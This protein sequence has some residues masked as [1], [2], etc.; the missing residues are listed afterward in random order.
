MFCTNCGKEL[1]PNDRFCANCGCEVKGSQTESRKYDNVVFNPPFRMEAEKKTAQILRNRE[2]FR[3]FK[4]ISDETNRRSARSKAKM[5]WNLEGFPESVTAQGRKSSFDWDSVIERRNSGRSMGFEKIDLSST[6]EH[7]KVDPEKD[8]PKAEE[9]AEDKISLGLPP[10]DSRVISL[11]ELEKELYD[12]EE[13]LRTDTARTAKYEPFRDGEI[14]DSDEL[15]AY[16]DGI[17]KT[18]KKEEDKLEEEAVENVR[19]GGPMK[20][21]LDDE[22]NRRAKAARAPMG[23]VWG[24]DPDE[25]IAQKKASKAKARKEAKMVWDLEEKKEEP[26]PEPEPAPP[27]QAEPEPAVQPEPKAYSAP[28]PAAEPEPVIEAVPEPA[29]EPVPEPVA[30]VIPEPVKEEVKE[31]APA[32]NHE[33]ARFIPKTYAEPE[34]KPL[35]TNFPEPVKHEPEEEPIP[36][37]EIHV[38]EIHVPKAEAEP[39][40][41]IEPEVEPESEVEAEYKDMIL[42]DEPEYLEKTRIFDQAEIKEWIRKELEEAE[43]E[44]EEVPEEEPSEVPYPATSKESK[45]PLYQS[46]VIHPWEM[47]PE[48]T[49]TPSEEP[50]AVPEEPET[51]EEPVQH[52]VVAEEPVYEEPAAEIPSEEPAAEA[53]P[54]PAEPEV[55]EAPA[56][57]EYDGPKPMFYT[58]SQKNNAFQ[59]LLKKER[60]RLDDMGAKYTPVNAAPKADKINVETKA[61]GFAYEEG[62]R[63]VEEVVQPVETSVADLS[64]D[65]KPNV[66]Q[67]KYSFMTDG[68]WLKEMKAASDLESLNKTKLR[69]SDLFP[70]PLVK[71]SESPRG[72]SSDDM[73]EEEK[74]KRVDDINKI[75][76]EEEPEKPKKHV[77]GNIIMVLLILVILFEGSVLAAKL[78]APDTK[79]AH[80][81]DVVIEKVLDLFSHK[82]KADSE[83]ADGEDVALSDADA[84]AGSYPAMITELALSADTIGDVAYS[85]DLS[86]T[87]VPQ[88]AFAGVESMELLGDSVWLDEDGVQTTYAQGIFQTVIN[89]YNEWKDR[90]TDENLVGINALEL[91]EIR[92]GENG[93]YILTGTTFA[94][95]EGNTQTTYQTC[96]VT[97]TDDSMFIDEIRTEEVVNG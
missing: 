74:Q 36:E 25:L 3:G 79:Y 75:F 16:L 14:E 27:V 42:N 47:Q 29:P 4:E 70:T 63:F 28:E 53:E 17:N 52:E 41:V 57:P 72:L 7:K 48:V 40:P 88:P 34:Y 1:K 2:E 12:L 69:Y 58:F 11:E 65:A 13:E 71:E 76:D 46:D 39:E 10:E 61:S 35:F 84:D 9:K 51:E 15:N 93:Y 30:E 97:V 21:N 26:K 31:P 43:K 77:V 38:P 90:N 62:G 19:N 73:T 91:G 92:A 6:M 64:G 83:T 23:L 20:W 49:E 87:N 67:F 80:I 95:A 50:E 59:E 22:S 44:P 55:P 32:V 18:K 45:R 96:Y 85:G 8:A 66:S 24:I 86:Y 82:D 5:D 56:E 89:Y 68:D 81:S 78:I 37:P 60:E 54:E 33:P 94:T